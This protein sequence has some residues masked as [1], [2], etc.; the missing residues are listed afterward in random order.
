MLS[1]FKFDE[2]TCD[3]SRSLPL[4]RFNVS[5]PRHAYCDYHMFATSRPV[6]L[7]LGEPSCKA[8]NIVQYPRRG[9]YVGCMVTVFRMCTN[10]V[11]TWWRLL[12]IVRVL[13]VHVPMVQ[14][15]CSPIFGKTTL[16]CRLIAGR[17]RTGRLL[18]SLNFLSCKYCSFFVRNACLPCAKISIRLKAREARDGYERRIPGLGMPRRKEEEGTR[19]DLIV[20]F[21]VENGD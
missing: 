7:L 10:V 5:L 17:T 21:M 12:C 8:T 6:C 4:I 15:R 1:R 20:H 19:G 18:Y 13:R 9:N 11:G 3:E 16:P 14:F 2:S